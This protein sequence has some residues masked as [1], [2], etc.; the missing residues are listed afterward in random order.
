M[1]LIRSVGVTVNDYDLNRLGNTL[2]HYEKLGCTGAELFIMPLQ[3]I[4][5]GELNQRRC[6][7]AAEACDKSNLEFSVHAPMSLNFLDRQHLE[8]HKQIC[9]STIEFCH[10]IGARTLVVHPGNSTVEQS[11]EGYDAIMA[12]E[13][14]IYREM[15]EYAASFD[16]VLALE[17]MPPTEDIIHGKVSNYG[18]IPHLVAKQIEAVG[19]DNFRGTLDFSHACIAAEY[20]GGDLL[21]S[22]STFQ[23]HVNH[24]HFHDSFGSAHTMKTPYTGEAA[25]WGMGDLHLP[26]GW[27]SLPWEDVLS[28]LSVQPDTMITVEIDHKYSSDFEI[29]SSIER[30][31][32]LAALLDGAHSEIVEPQYILAAA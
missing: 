8:L 27:G 12:Q 20:H 17:N 5:G 28:H 11:I 23:K 7:Q 9:R 15:A 10:F 6:D 22:L 26:L 2:Q 16:I 32:E 31:H 30:A 14:S 18:L 21:G 24:L 1:D 4:F 13:A 3:V 19:C 25:A 29:A